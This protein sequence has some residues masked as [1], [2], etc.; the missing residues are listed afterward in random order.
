MADDQAL[1]SLSL[2]ADLAAAAADPEL[3]ALQRRLQDALLMQQ[4]R[5]VFQPIFDIHSLRLHSAEAL[6]RWRHPELGE[7]SPSRF[8]PL[9]ERSSLIIELGR[10]V[11]DQTTGQI[12]QWQAQ[13]LAPVPV[14][15]NVSGAEL[16]DPEFPQQV[17][18]ALQRHGLAGELLGVEVTEH[19]LISD[20]PRVTENLHATGALG[21]GFSLDDFGT[22]Y[23]SFKYLRHLPIRALKIDREFVAGVDVDVRDQRIVRAMVA[24]AHSLQVKVIA[25]GVETEAELATLRK[26]KCDYVQGFLTGRPMAPEDFAG[27]LS[28]AGATSPT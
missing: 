21:V 5:M 13:G 4:L 20:F 22:G 24:L 15:I 10:H 1:F 11:L 14:A 25:E 3:I 16:K 28:A 19:G 27:L 26:L 17:A 6:L 8:I 9:A 7:V 18:A 12:A 23:S 2:S